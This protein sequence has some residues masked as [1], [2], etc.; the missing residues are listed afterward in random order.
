MKKEKLE[1]PSLIKNRSVH[2]P[3]R[4]EDLARLVV[5]VDY[6]CVT[7]TTSVAG[8]ALYEMSTL[9]RVLHLLW[10]MASRYEVVWEPK[11]QSAAKREYSWQRIASK[12]RPPSDANSLQGGGSKAIRSM[13]RV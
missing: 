3:V 12:A 1:W 11:C 2:K 6:T 10:E 9:R 13:S 8:Q 4:R 7:P 5:N